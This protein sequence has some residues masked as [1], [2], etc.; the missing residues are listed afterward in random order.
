MNVRRGRPSAQKVFRGISPWSCSDSRRGQ[1]SSLGPT[2]P[3][4]VD[5]VQARKGPAADFRG[6][7]VVLARPSPRQDLSYGGRASN[8][9]TGRPG[10]RLRRAPEPSIRPGAHPTELHRVAEGPDGVVHQR[11]SVAWTDGLG[12]P[13]RIPNQTFS[14]GD[15]R[16]RLHAGAPGRVHGD[17][18]A[19]DGGVSMAVSASR[20]AAAEV[21]CVTAS[22][23][24]RSASM[25]TGRPPGR[26]AS[27][28][29]CTES[30]SASTSAA[31]F[32]S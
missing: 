6:I 1:R 32:A 16:A 20:A 17:M 21:R 22:D 18:R 31:R 3:A 19:A 9:G 4:G 15:G 13:P 23:S 2:R 7:S 28:Q 26:P 27:C 25:S 12:N 5:K 29:P 14:I 11:A 30:R 24:R 8:N 10:R